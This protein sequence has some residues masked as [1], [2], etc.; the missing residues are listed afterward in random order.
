MPLFLVFGRAEKGPKTQVWDHTKKVAPG[1]RKRPGIRGFFA[2]FS[3][4]FWGFRGL[5]DWP[6]RPV[7]NGAWKSVSARPAG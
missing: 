6:S 3:A 2:R 4:C 7:R 1:Q 5:A